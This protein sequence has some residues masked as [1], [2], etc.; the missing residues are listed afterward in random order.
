[1]INKSLP[2]HEINEIQAE[3]SNNSPLLYDLFAIS[4]HFGGTGGG[5]YT[6]FC[7]YINFYV[8][9]SITGEWYD[10]DDSSVDLIK[11]KDSLVS[12]NAYILFYRR[13][14]WCINIIFIIHLFFSINIK[15]RVIYE[16]YVKKQSFL[17]E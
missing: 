17:F 12:E 16:K 7:K 6:A 2:T 14:N 15:Q 13:K 8:R 10:F 3:A 11:N 5:H 1:M 9:N 4:N